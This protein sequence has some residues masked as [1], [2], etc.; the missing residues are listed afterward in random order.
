MSKKLLVICP[1]P[2][3]VAP[4]QRLKFEQYYDSFR[5]DGWEVTVKPFI[6]TQFWRIIYQKGNLLSKLAYTISGYW[7]RLVLLF[8]IPRYNAVYVHLWVTP[9]GPP[10]FERFVRWRAR[11]MIYDIDDLIYLSSSKSKAHPLVTWI[12]GRNKP[13]LLMKTADHVITCTPYL[14]QFVR[15][16]NPNTT[17]ISSTVDTD[18]R[19]KMR[20]QLT[21]GSKVTLGWSGSLSTAK[22]FYLLAGVLKELVKKYQ[23]HIVVMGDAN[24]A[25]EG[26]EIEA[27]P[28]RQDIEMETLNRFDI[29]L[30]P[31]PNEEWV[32]GKSGL[33]AIQYMSLGIPTVA[34][35]IGANF[36]VIENGVSG[37]LVN[38]DAE[39]IEALSLLIENAELR[40]QIGEAARKRVEQLF[41]V[42]SNEQTYL[43]IINQAI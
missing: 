3:G 14:D 33:K 29:G 2:E 1:Y 39:W 43:N 26:L 42:R 24:V 36:R 6:S 34:S 35:A 19:Y 22:Y 23:L 20:N 7:H 12:K 8:S 21:T 31:L 16:L 32:Y 18:T 40:K 5:N 9:F 15:R 30:Y 11:Y 37:F 10:F 27:L 4:S 13:L 41:S 17:D 28:W 25:V 38:S